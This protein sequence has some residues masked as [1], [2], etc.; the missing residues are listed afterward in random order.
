MTVKLTPLLASPPTVTTTLPVV[1]PDGTGAVM[2]VAL[3]LVG[4]VAIPWNVTVLLPWDAPKFVPVIVTDTPMVPEVTLRPVIPGVTVNFTPLLDTPSTVTTTFPVVTL[5]GTTAVMVVAPQLVGVTVTPLNVTVFVPCADPKS[6][7]VMV[8]EVPTGAEAGF[9]LAIFGVPAT[10]KE[11]PLLG[12]PATVTTTLPVV[13]PV[14]TG[15][16]ML[17]ALQLVGVPAMPLNCTVLLPCVAPKLVPVMTIEA[18]TGAEVRLRVS[19]LGVAKTVKLTPLLP[20]PLTV[21]TTFPVVAPEGTGTVMLDALQLV[22]VP[23]VPLNVTVLVP[24]EDPKLFPVMV[25]AVPTAADAGFKVVTLGVAKIVKL[26]PL[27]GTP[28]TVT[29]TFPVVAVAGTGTIMLV[30]LQLEGAA[31]IPLNVTVLVP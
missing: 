7:P 26:A 5:A 15:T 2:L 1:A 21:T 16:V 19:I 30:A 17:V 23:A 10:V 6:V 20:T 27:L 11:T 29:T 24:C 9:R 25:M 12:T 31:V 28:P 13:A 3:Q 14:G 4:V 22:G 8:T 18:P